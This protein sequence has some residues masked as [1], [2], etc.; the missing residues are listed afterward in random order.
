MAKVILSRVDTARSGGANAMLRVSMRA[1]PGQLPGRLGVST[2]P[3]AHDQVEVIT[4][5]HRACAT[6]NGRPAGRHA[7]ALIV[8]DIFREF[9]GSR[10][11]DICT[12]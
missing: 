8:L 1:S 9:G 6:R 2:I 5:G 7:A 4:P 3:R 11:V 10:C 12:T